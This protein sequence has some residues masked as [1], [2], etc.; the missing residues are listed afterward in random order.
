[1][2][3]LSFFSNTLIDFFPLD[4]KKVLFKLLFKLLHEGFIFGFQNDCLRQ[5]S[6]SNAGIHK[7]DKSMQQRNPGPVEYR[8]EL[9]IAKTKGNGHI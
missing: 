4:T 7:G 2:L 6:L 3:K 1:M 9:T 8:R 5:V